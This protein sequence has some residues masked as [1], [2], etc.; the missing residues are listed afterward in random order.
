MATNFHH[1]RGETHF[2]YVRRYEDFKKVRDM[3]NAEEIHHAQEN[4]D[5]AF[6]E[7][8][9]FSHKQIDPRFEINLR[10]LLHEAEESMRIITL[11]HERQNCIDRME[12]FDGP[13]Q[14]IHVGENPLIIH[15]YNE[16]P[17]DWTNY[18]MPAGPR[19]T[20]PGPNN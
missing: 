4:I 17:I 5:F 1:N 19:Y 3:L 7:Y 8:N 14:S 6:K 11:R 15:H 20:P 9:E 18:F 13:H 10:R 2:G 12:F 16:D